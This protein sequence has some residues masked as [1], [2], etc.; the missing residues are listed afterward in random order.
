MRQ[1]VYTVGEQDYRI[2]H[3]LGPNYF[4]TT[5]CG[6]KV[7]RWTI[8]IQVRDPLGTGDGTYTFT[9]PEDGDS[10]PVR[11]IIVVRSAAGSAHWDGNGQVT[12]VDGDPPQLRF[13]NVRGTVT[14]KVPRNPTVT[15]PFDQP[16]FDVPLHVGSFCASS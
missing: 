5:K 8:E 15:R 6:G 9:I 11:L 3:T 2:D 13:G 7:G 4:R 16:P 14:I 10:A 12:F 1:V